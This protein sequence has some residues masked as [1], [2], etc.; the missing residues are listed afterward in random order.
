VNFLEVKEYIYLIPPCCHHQN[1]V[2]ECQIAIMNAVREEAYESAQQ[3][4][5]KYS[6]YFH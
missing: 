4:I 3:L 5:Y 1:N 6:L 2:H